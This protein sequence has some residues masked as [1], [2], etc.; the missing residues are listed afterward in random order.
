MGC[1]CVVGK[2]YLIMIAQCQMSE[3]SC[4]AEK[5]PGGGGIWGELRVSSGGR[6]KAQTGMLARLGRDTAGQEEQSILETMLTLCHQKH[7]APV[8]RSCLLLC[9]FV[10]WLV[11]G[12]GENCPYQAL[13]TASL[14]GCV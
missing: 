3:N 5:Q 14:L 8:G 12:E 7:G 4:P 9:A 13:P 10:G 2:L 11:E 1:N 6:D